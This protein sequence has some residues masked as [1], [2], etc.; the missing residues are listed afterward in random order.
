MSKYNYSPGGEGLDWTYTQHKSKSFIEPGGGEEWDLMVV[1]DQMTDTYI[2][3]E[4]LGPNPEGVGRKWKPIH[5]PLEFGGGA[6]NTYNNLKGLFPNRRVDCRYPRVKDGWITKTRL[7]NSKTG[8]LLL[9][10]DENRVYP[11]ANEWI[12]E[13]LKSKVWVAVDYGK[14]TF[15]TIKSRQVVD[16]SY[17]H[18]KGNPLNWPT[19]KETLFFC[20]NEEYSKYLD[21]YN[22]CPRLVVTNGPGWIE[23]KEFGIMKALAPAYGVR[24]KNVCGAGDSTM[25]SIIWALEQGLPMGEALDWGNVGGALACMD[26][27]THTLRVEEMEVFKTI[28]GHTKS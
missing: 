21:E 14:G 25:A 3:C 15:C 1:G 6:L 4:D 10:L 26:P 18:T 28:Y 24:I 11:P 12:P 7:I 5:P 13:G 22:T 2:K 20:N 16:W 23:Y 8:E 19:T 27:Y 17:I 9:R